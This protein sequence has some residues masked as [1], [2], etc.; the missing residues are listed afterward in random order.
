M[1]ENVNDLAMKILD[2]LDPSA[3]PN[4]TDSQNPALLRLDQEILKLQK[5]FTDK[6]NSWLESKGYK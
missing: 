1:S 3:L 2:G 4:Y 6:Q 5:I